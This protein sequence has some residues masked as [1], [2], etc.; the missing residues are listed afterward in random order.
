MTS[1]QRYSL[2][3]PLFLGEGGETIPIGV[4]EAAVIPNK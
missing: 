2:C 3:D 4:A 1:V